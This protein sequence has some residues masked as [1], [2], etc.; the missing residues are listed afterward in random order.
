M[1]LDRRNFLRTATLGCACCLAAR[2]AGAAEISH[3]PGAAPCAWR[4]PCG[5]A[6]DLRR[7]D[8][9]R[10]LGPVAAQFQGLPA[11]T[12][13][14]ADRPG[15]RDE[16]RRRGVALGY[17]MLALRIVNNGHTIQVNADPGSSC[18]I[19]GVKYDLLQFHFHHP[20]EHL[21]A[22]KP[23]D[24]ECHFVHK[25]GAGD[26]AV[27]GVFFKPGAKNRRSRRSSMRCRRRK[28]PRRA[29]KDRSIR[30]RCFPSPAAISATWARSRRRPARRA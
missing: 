11:R 14:N 9:S 20:S 21:L 12:R 6:L 24:L 8:R 3:A 25:S 2:Y 28:G 22:G 16:G 7:G 19:G 4:R 13:A 23:F 5:A 10:A 17:Q 1:T 29:P 27:V 26:L 30:A 15:R 18:T